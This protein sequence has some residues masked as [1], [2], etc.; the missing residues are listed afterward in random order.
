M[1]DVAVI[2]GGMAGYT[3]ALYAARGG[4]DTVVFE[5]LLP[6]GQ[7]ATI[8]SLENFPGYPQGVEGIAL[9]TALQE[10][11]E[12]F[13]AHTRYEQ[14]E[15]LVPGPPLTLLGDNWQE[16]ARAVIIASGA[17]PRKLG[18]PQE[19]ELIGRGVSYCATCDGPL[20]RHK[21]VAVVGGGDT[22]LTDAL[23]LAN[24]AEQVY[25][26]HRRDR[27][28]GSPLLAA[29]VEASPHITLLMEKR[30]SALQGDKRL[31]GLTLASTAGQPDQDLAVEGLFVAVGVEPAT[32]AFASVLELDPA[33]RIITSPGLKTSLPGVFAAGDCRDT[34]LR[35]AVTAAA[36]GAL[37]AASAQEYVLGLE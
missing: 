24:Y 36:D 25:L 4:L 31:S 26:I 3:A 30:I 20:Y 5:G 8:M 6:G 29:R 23:V 19:L 32:A 18:L 12:K 37:A 27:F 14:V 21:A 28:R 16:Q 22:A 9:T 15:S 33:G 10:Q 13:G 34:L 7:T 35:Q 1:I 2:G 17:T 11:A